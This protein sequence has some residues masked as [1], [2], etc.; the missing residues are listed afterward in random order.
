MAAALPM[1]VSL[2]APPMAFSMMR[3][4]A[5]E[6]LPMASVPPLPGPALENDSGRRSI[7][8]LVLKPER[9]SVSLPPASQMQNTQAG[10]DAV[11]EKAAWPTFAL[12]P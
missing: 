2:P 4:R 3:P 7:S 8:E 10:A 9:S 11:S 6:I 12:K 1:I 5:I